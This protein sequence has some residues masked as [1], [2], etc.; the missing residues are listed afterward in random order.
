MSVLLLILSLFSFA[1]PLDKNFKYQMEG[2]FSTNLPGSSRSQEVRFTLLWNEKDNAISGHYRDDMFSNGSAVSGTTGPGGK[3]FSTSFSRRMQNV[4]KL[5]FTSIA[6]KVD[7]GTIPLMVFMKDHVD[8]TVD[9]NATSAAI[10]VRAD[11]VDESESC[12]NGFGE[13][14]GYCGLYKG[15]ITEIMD[16]GNYCN[17]PDYGFRMELSSGARVNLYFYYSDT[18]VGIPTHSLGAFEVVPLA[19]A[20]S[21]QE[22]HC[23]KLVGT[24]FPT[25]G[26]QSLRLSGNFSKLNNKN[27]FS[28][29]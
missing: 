28:G 17:L 8:M 29:T 20:I 7:G 21:M 22:R 18:T 3:V 15:G 19:P 4:V 12:V 14:R 5:I 2:S 27:R 6:E 9:Q 10:Q 24:N 16:G 23:G 11:F 25:T 1:Q 13:V 26:C